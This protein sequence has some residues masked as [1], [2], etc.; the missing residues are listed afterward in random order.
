M[1]T[2][3]NPEIARKIAKARLMIASLNNHQ[4]RVTLAAMQARQTKEAPVDEYAA[5]ADV[6]G[7]I[8]DEVESRSGTAAMETL[9]DEMD[10]AYPNPITP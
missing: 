2:A 6:I 7:W 3:T 4:L 10:A 5:C 8:F 9:W 1:T